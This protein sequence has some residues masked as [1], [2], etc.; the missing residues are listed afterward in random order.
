MPSRVAW[1]MVAGALVLTLLGC[2]ADEKGVEGLV[3]PQELTPTPTPTAR[4]VASATPTPTPTWR[5]VTEPTP[6]EGVEPS[7]PG[8][9]VVAPTPQ[10]TPDPSEL[11]PEIHDEPP[12]DVS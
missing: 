8:G 2:F 5:P 3:P 4:P 12:E 10:P 6:F 11:D 7:R 9:P 1:R